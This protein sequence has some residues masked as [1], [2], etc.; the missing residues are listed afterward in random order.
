MLDR[1]ERAGFVERVRGTQ[2][3]RK[4]HVRSTGRHEAALGDVFSEV[5]DAFGNVAARHPDQELRSFIAIMNEFNRAAFDLA[6]S[7]A[8]RDRV[9]DR[10]P[11]RD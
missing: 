10:D 4:V 3:R 8:E 6:R 2:D 11:D 1:L 7:L 9:R 5:A